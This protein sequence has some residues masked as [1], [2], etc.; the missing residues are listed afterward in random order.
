MGETHRSPLGNLIITGGEENVKEK[1][2]R[3]DNKAMELTNKEA[4]KMLKK[5]RLYE[6]EEIIDNYPED[7]RDG[8]DDW[9]MLA[10]EAGYYYSCYLEDGHC[11]RD[12]LQDAR[13]KLRETK[14]GKVIPLDPYTLRP[15]RGYYPSDIQIAK[16]CVNEFNRLERLVKRLEKMGYYSKWL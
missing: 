1:I 11:F 2:P 16:D 6:L 3:K 10:D 9:Q 13:E 8:R 4:I 5:A 15:R 12:D 14:Y 7:E